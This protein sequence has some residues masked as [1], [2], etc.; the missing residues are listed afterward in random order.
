MRI[1]ESFSQG[2]RVHV[3]SLFRQVLDLAD[4]DHLMDYWYLGMRERNSQRELIPLYL[5]L[6]PIVLGCF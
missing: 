3:E 2:I 4:S 5:G 6:Q 1:I